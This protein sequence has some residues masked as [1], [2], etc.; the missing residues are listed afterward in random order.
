MRE[1]KEARELARL[2]VR[3]SRSLN[4]SASALITVMD[5]PL[6]TTVGNALEVR[7]SVRLLRGEEVPAALS[8]TV[9]AVAAGLLRL[10][11]MSGPKDAVEKAI[12]SGAAYEKLQGLVAIQGG[13]VE[14]L[15]SLP[16]SEETREVAAPR[17]GYISRFGALEVGRAAVLLGAGR[18]NKGEEVDP[19]AGIELLV[20]V[21]DKVEEGQP[22]A[23]MYGARNAEKARMLILKALEVSDTPVRRPPVILDSL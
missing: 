4:V 5:E 16:A 17:T 2:L 15:E 22:V 19:G 11:G 23:K 1:S 10:K 8:E 12:F 21:G 13:N 18:N 3:L 20:K 9:R 7:E 6:G 14:A